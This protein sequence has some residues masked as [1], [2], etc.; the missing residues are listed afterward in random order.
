MQHSPSPQNRRAFVNLLVLLGV[1][2]VFA[3]AGFAYEKNI[4]E[5]QKFGSTVLQ[6]QL[7]DTIGTF[8]TNVN[9]S[10]SSIATDV[11]T[12]TST[13]ATYGNL[14]TLNSPLPVANGG[15]GATTAPSNAQF[16]SASGTQPAWK[17]FTFGGGIISTT[18]PTSVTIDTT[19]LDATVNYNWTGTHTFSSGTV[20]LNATTT[21]TYLAPVGAIE[22]YAS[23]TA[24][25]GWLLCNGQTVATATYPSLFAL[26]GYYYAG[27]TSTFGVPD[28][29]GRFVAGPS[30][31]LSTA[32]GATGG[33]LTAT[34]TVK[35]GL[36][37]IR[38]A[39]DGAGVV[40]GFNNGT[41]PG[42]TATGNATSTAIPPYIIFNYIIKF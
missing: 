33:S 19:G 30:S 13:Q 18:T 40:S 27:S 4:A 31:T 3:L 11:A 24:P 36:T 39:S 22:M 32:N 35:T 16:L 26:L 1:A 28:M 20:S 12:I 6:T 37:T 8:R 14:V 23:T 25:N 10:L 34:G 41:D 2:A 17:T 5:Q 38:T 21:A 42:G 7:T 29:R 15:L 9:S